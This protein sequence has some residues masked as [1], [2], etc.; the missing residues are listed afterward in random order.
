MVVTVYKP[1]SFFTDRTC[2]VHGASSQVETK[3][4][5]ELRARERER[6]RACGLYFFFCKFICHLVEIYVA[7]CR[8]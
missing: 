2:D 5:G 3:V 7:M 4:V 8:N 6:K 1:V